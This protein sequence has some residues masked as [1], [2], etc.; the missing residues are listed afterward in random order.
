MTTN[1]AQEHAPHVLLSVSTSQHI[2]HEGVTYAAWDHIEH[3]ADETSETDIFKPG[4]PLP[5]SGTTV[6]SG[7]T[8]R[9]DR[10]S[11]APHDVEIRGPYRHAYHTPESAT[12]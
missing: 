11:T 4:V 9:S 1:Q 12:A 8:W 5:S 2:E 10:G 3:W 7:V 6:L